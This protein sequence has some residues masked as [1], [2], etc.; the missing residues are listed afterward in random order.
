[1][2]PRLGDFLIDSP[3]FY[4]IHILY[5]IQVNK[6]MSNVNINKTSSATDIK[7]TQDIIEILKT[8]LGIQHDITTDD[9]LAFDL[10]MD[11]LDTMI[12]CELIETKLNL[13]NVTLDIP[14]K[15]YKQLKVLDLILATQNAYKK[16]QFQ[17]QQKQIQN[18]HKNGKIK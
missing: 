14:L 2:I 12:I 6:K 4:A 5:M 18:I 8:E 1:M 16:L 7:I 15:K 13:L 10:G 9:S 3:L 11:S 17:Y